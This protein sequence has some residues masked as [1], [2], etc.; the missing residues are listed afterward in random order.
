MVKKSTKE[1]KI[2][3]KYLPNSNHGR[4]RE[5]EEQKRSCDKLNINSIK[6]EVSPIITLNVE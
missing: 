4:K 5:A 6:V 3:L 2:T 1:L